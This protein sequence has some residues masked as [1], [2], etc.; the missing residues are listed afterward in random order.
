MIQTQ[1]LP[2]VKPQGVLEPVAYFDGAMLTGVTVSHEGRIFVNSPR[3]ADKV[4]YMEA[5]IKNGQPVST[6]GS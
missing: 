3:W 2:A 1:E 6:T 4:F 5:E